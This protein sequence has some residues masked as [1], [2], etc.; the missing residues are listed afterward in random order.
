MTH[1]P[2]PHAVRRV[3]A[4]L[5]LVL[6]VAGSATGC[7]EASV[8]SPPSGVDELTVPTPSPDPQDFVDEVDN[9][10]LPLVAGA[11]WTYEV[12]GGAGGRVVVT[13]ADEPA[14]IAGVRATAVQ[15][16][17]TLNAPEPGEVDL[18]GWSASP[19]TDYYAQ[20]TRGNVWWLGREGEWQAGQ[21]GAQA[22][23][24]MLAT[25]R[26][27]DGYRQALVP[28]AVGATPGLI[29]E[30]AALDGTA[31]TGAGAFDDMVVIETTGP[32]GVAQRRFYARG[33]GLVVTDTLPG[34]AS[35]S[36]A[37]TSYDG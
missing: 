30:V 23:I 37:L 16:V 19:T 20:D 29:A 24:A 15:T 21:D 1:R 8:V 36:V 33:T 35:R 5:G 14:T 31:E 4:A 32:G 12:G 7:S 2:A 6:L 18:S 26:R 11:T 28:G 9:P 25:P 13:V 10:W 34:D 27:G 17:Q 22:G 3:L